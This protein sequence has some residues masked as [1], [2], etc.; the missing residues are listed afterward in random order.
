MGSSWTPQPISATTGAGYKPM[1]QSMVNLQTAA[2]QTP[3]YPQIHPM[4]V[5]YIFKLM[6][7]IEKYSSQNQK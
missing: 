4:M 3:L 1:N 7:L 2:V 5:R 6:F